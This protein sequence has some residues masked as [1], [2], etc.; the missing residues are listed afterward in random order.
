MSPRLS[1]IV[2]SLNGA[3]R[4]DRCLRALDAQTIRSS[5]ELIVVDDGSADETS[6]VARAYD[7]ILVRHLH[8]RGVSAARNS[9]V[10]AASAPIVAFLD[11]DC[12]PE[13]QWAE[14]LL[15]GY[16]NSVVA[17]GGPLSVGGDSGIIIDYLKRHNPLSPQELELAKSD[18]LHYRLFLYLRRQWMMPKENDRRYVFAIPTAN[19]SVLRQAFLSIGGFDERIRFGS[20]DEDLCRRLSYAFP[21][22][23]L[24]FVPEARVTHHFKPSLRDTLRRSRVY[25][26]GS[27]LMY[28]KWSHVRP[29]FFPGPVITLALLVLSIRL[30]FL[31]AV[32][33]LLPLFLYPLG[34][35]MAINEH[36]VRYLLDSYL[37]LAQEASDNI[38]FI[39]GLWR[40]RNFASELAG[41]SAQPLEPGHEA[42]AR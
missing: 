15:A 22:K 20:E 39:E 11:D 29:T 3:R 23:R 8:N 6:D 16:D 24:L 26:R 27:A 31:A 38:G 37:Q 9:G 4:V 12:E 35:R 14:Q 1:V 34:L 36:R 33:L 18:K 13:Q 42:E 21:S 41:I 28:R 17:V 10:G 30:P 7:T 19:M 40:Y 2:S 5:L 32:A 25:G